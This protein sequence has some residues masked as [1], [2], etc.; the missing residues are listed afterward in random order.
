MS[1]KA[2]ELKIEVERRIINCCKF[3]GARIKTLGGFEYYVRKTNLKVV[4]PHKFLISVKNVKMIVVLG[5]DD[6][7]YLF[8][9]DHPITISLL[10]KLLDRI[11]GK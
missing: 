5:E 4:I 10:A 7:L 8:D 1:I 9:Y 3:H 11:R 2:L 6:E